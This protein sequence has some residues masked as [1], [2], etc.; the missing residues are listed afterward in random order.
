MTF[1]TGVDSLGVPSTLGTPLA[2]WALPVARESSAALVDGHIERLWFRLSEQS[3]RRLGV[4]AASTG[5]GVSPEDHAALIGA[6]AMIAEAEGVLEAEQ[7]FAETYLCVPWVCE[8]VAAA[9]RER[10]MPSEK[11]ARRREQTRLAVAR[12]REKQRA[13][14][15]RKAER[16][17]EA[18]EERMERS[19]RQKAIMVD[20]EGV[21]LEDGKHVY[22]YMAAC[23]SDGTVLGELYD[24]SGIKSRAAFEFL[25]G[26]PKVDEDGLPYFGVF[27]YGLGY[28]TAKWLERLKN[29]PIYDLMHS[30]DLTPKAKVGSLSMVFVGKC[31]ELTDKRAPKGFKKTKVWDILKGFQ[32]TFVNALKD[33][34]VG[35]AE[36]WAWLEDMKAQRGKFA[37]ADWE[38][39]T[40]YCRE[41]CR[42]GAEL[43]ETYLRA[44]VDAGI[45]LRGKY[46]GAGSTSD[47]FLT[48]MDAVNKKCTRDFVSKECD[49]YRQMR[50]AFSRAFFGGRAETSQ[51]GRIAGPVWTA[52]IASAYPHVLYSLP[53]VKHG[54]WRQTRGRGLRRSLKVAK[55]AVVHFRI[56]MDDSRDA[57]LD[58]EVEEGPEPEDETPECERTVHQRAERM[59]IGGD[60]GVPSWGPLPYRTERGAIVFPVSHPGGWAWQ[61]EFETAERHF[62]GVEPTEAWVLRGRC[63]CGRPYE[64]IGKYYLLRLQWGKEGRGKVLK[65]GYN[66]CYGKTAQTIGKNPKYACRAVAGHITSNTRARLFDAIMSAKESWNVFYAATDGL[67]A[68]EALAP[69]NPPKNETAKVSPTKWLGVWEVAPLQKKSAGGGTVDDDGDVFVVQPGFWFSVASGGG[70]KT[71][72]APLSM[73]LAF[74]Q[75]ILEQWDREPTRKPRGLPKMSRFH[76]AKTSIRPPKKG[77]S[78]YQ[79]DPKYGRWTEEERKIAYVVNPKR[80]ALIDQGGGNYRLR[81]WWMRDGQPESAEYK[82]DTTFGDIDDA[83]DEQPDF[84]ESFA[85]GVGE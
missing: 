22:R 15:Q 12:Y 42:L 41:E 40:Q 4:I 80:S 85:G 51:L 28:D 74:K 66:G 72:G 5:T 70:I 47:A 6:L 58:P 1:D 14:E 62:S 36:E 26:L 34:K 9:E 16:Q 11:G 68:T 21:S 27:G 63:K 18:S 61:S 78:K 55:L 54:K 33:W 48:L 75:Q 49:A 17:E 23:R 64:D 37:D 65:L 79:R 44:H 83:N 77:E 7:D 3:R 38:T 24:E 2:N 82:K 50:S 39:V 43:V 29:K 53:C 67:M 13:A 81:T 31:L 76:G 84:V 56:G 45:D 10:A 25:A 59:K 8:A 35:T 60:A 32:S 46:H 52:D 69:P 73:V 19:K 57:G 71:R 20:G 30:E